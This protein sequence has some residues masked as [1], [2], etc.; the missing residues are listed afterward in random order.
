M[1]IIFN[2]AYEDN[3]EIS[4]GMLLFHPA[5]NGAVSCTI[6]SIV[7]SNGTLTR[8]DLMLTLT[9]NVN[10][11]DVATMNITTIAIVR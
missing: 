1:Y 3:I 7:T 2:F 11:V 10:G 4:G 5:E 9:T 8:T 6:I